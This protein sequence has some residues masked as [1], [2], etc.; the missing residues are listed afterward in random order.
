AN[1]DVPPTREPMLE[2]GRVSAR[3][4]RVRTKAE[5][6]RRFLHDFMPDA[7]TFDTLTLIRR[8]PADIGRVQLDFLLAQSQLLQLERL[9]RNPMG[10]AVANSQVVPIASGKLQIVGLVSCIMRC[11]Q[12][13]HEIATIIPQRLFPC[14]DGILLVDLPLLGGT[15]GLTKFPVWFERIPATCLQ[16]LCSFKA[17]VDER[18]ERRQ[19]AA[20]A[21]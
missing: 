17:R 12:G 4:A 6:S 7:N 16:Q 21:L 14:F 18:H 10:C 1:R 20:L 15:E 11:S 5:R 9:P 19:G 2:N 8:L 13:R 3:H